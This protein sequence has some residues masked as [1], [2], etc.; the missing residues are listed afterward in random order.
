MQ[1]QLNML[2]NNVSLAPTMGEQ[3]QYEYSLI[4][5]FVLV[6]YINYILVEGREKTIFIHH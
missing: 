5:I 3:N 1:K 6:L 4:C 2:Y